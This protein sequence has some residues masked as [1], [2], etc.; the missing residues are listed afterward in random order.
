MLVPWEGTQ[1]DNNGVC[2]PTSLFSPR[3]SFV[4]LWSPKQ[5]EQGTSQI[6][7]NFFIQLSLILFE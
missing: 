5:P 6:I 2:M 1:P 7:I 4:S 3:L